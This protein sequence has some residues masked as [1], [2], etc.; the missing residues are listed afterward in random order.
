MDSLLTGLQSAVLLQISR[1]QTKNAD[2]LFV[3]CTRCLNGHQQRFSCKIDYLRGTNEMDPYILI[4]LLWRFS[5]E[6]DNLI[7]TNEMDP[8]ILIELQ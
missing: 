4:E 1:V 3:A 6:I 2:A 5:C 7:R 8:Y